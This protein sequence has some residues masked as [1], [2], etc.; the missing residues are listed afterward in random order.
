M[1]ISR[2]LI[3]ISPNQIQR[4]FPHK[5]GEL[6]RG[7][8]LSKLPDG[9]YLILIAGRELKAK[10]PIDLKGKHLFKVIENNNQLILKLIQQT[11]SDTN[12]SHT[13][14]QFSSLNNYKNDPLLIEIAQNYL[15]YN[16]ILN[17]NEL[18]LIFRFLKNQKKNQN[19]RFIDTIMMMKS[20][21]IKITTQRLNQWLQFDENI[22]QL[23]NEISRLLKNENNKQLLEFLKDK[24][25]IPLNSNNLK[26][27]IHN[28]LSRMNYIKN[29]SQ[30]GTNINFSGEKNIF[31]MDLLKFMSNIEDNKLLKKILHQ[32][33]GDKE[34]SLRSDGNKD[35]YFFS[36]P[37]IIDEDE[38]RYFK[39]KVM[40]PDKS[41]EE[42]VFYFDIDLP[43]LNSIRGLCTVFN[44]QLDISLF[45]QTKEISDYLNKYFKEFYK[46]NEIPITKWN[47][48]ITQENHPILLIQRD[49]T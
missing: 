23:E 15:K 2:D 48:Q 36:F 7:E 13:L 8:I 24:Y 31:I 16:Q 12:V 21:G 11:K 38:I 46:D 19:T 33:Q 37:L 34:S 41:K 39:L 6:V 30:P 26:H 32:Y 40:I 29:F 17:E 43:N 3:S 18:L 27:L 4:N 22:S 35:M 44:D 28:F 9:Y 47:V 1:E 10:S 20:K 5:V 42:F 49:I 45:T 14:N 25:L